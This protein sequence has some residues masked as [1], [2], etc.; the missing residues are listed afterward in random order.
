MPI[1][2]DSVSGLP[3]DYFQASGTQSVP[4]E[5]DKN[6]FLNLLVTSLKYQDPSEPMSTN[7]LMAQTTQLA[8]MEQLTTMTQLSQESFILQV[9]TSAMG[10][11]GRTVEYHDGEAMRTGVVTAV[12]FSASPPLIGIGDTTVTFGSVRAVV[13]ASDSESSDGHPPAGPDAGEAVSAA[14]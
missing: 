12:D 7:D 10:L 14:S 4:G 6:A 2:V 9:Q 13:A 11:V 3:A 8:T 5:L 1:S